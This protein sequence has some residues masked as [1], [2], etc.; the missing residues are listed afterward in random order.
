MIEVSARRGLFPK[1]LTVLKRIFETVKSLLQALLFPKVCIICRCASKDDICSECIK[2]VTVSPKRHDNV[3]DIYPFG[4][5]FYYGKYSGELKKAFG[6]YKFDGEIW[7]GAAFGRL[8]YNSFREYFA[9]YSALLYVPASRSG[10]MQRGF[11]QCKEVAAVIAKL[12]GLPIMDTL[13][14][15]KVAR[16][17]SR[18]GFRTRQENFGRFVL[19]DISDFEMQKYYRGKRILLIDDVLTTGS[20]VRECGQLLVERAGAERVDVMLIATGRADIKPF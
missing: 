3:Q 9:D 13:V 15:A 6:R 19:K 4:S 11:D 18:L 8:L 5:I 2:K 17:Q 7:L 1:T 16:K 14:S 20:T 12:S 10:Y